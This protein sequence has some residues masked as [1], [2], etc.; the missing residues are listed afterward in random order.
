MNTPKVTIGLILFKGEKYLSQSLPTLADQ[1][2]PNLEFLWRDQ[3]PNGE[4]LEY[5]QKNLPAITQKISIEKG[6][7]LMHSGGHNVLMRKMSGEYYFCCSYDMLYSPDFVSKIVAELEK[8][9]N[10]KYGSATCKIMRWDF[11]EDPS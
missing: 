4:A 9:E 2:Y 6:E 11:R 8:S 7:N 1:D 3:S 5:V 10:K